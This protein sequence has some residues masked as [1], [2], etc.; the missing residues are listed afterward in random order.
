M[1]NP[2]LPPGADPAGDSIPAAPWRVLI[3]D[4]SGDDPKWIIATVTA[5][6]D[7]RAA[8]MLANGRRYGDWP[9]VTEWVRGQ[10][11]SRVRLVPLTAVVWR[12]D[13]EGSA[14]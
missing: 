9:A 1:S 13:R 14:G 10:L 12:I 7:V 8:V 11:G 3:L 6:S 5:P 2:A 4:P